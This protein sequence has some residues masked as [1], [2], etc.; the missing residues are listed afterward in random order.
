M[1]PTRLRALLLLGAAAFLLRAGCAVLTQYRPIFP[2][3]YFTDAKLVD[4]VA[5]ALVNKT[6]SETLFFP[7]SLSQRLQV[8]F[9]VRLYSVVGPRPLA[10]KLVNAAAGAAAAVLLAASLLT[11]FGPAAALT[12]GTLFAV[13]PSAVFFTSHNL[14]EAPLA[15]FVFT[16]LA[17]LLPLFRDGAPAARN[18]ARA[19]VALG[20]LTGAGFCRPPVLLAMCTAFAIAFLLE[21][22]RLRK[23]PPRAAAGL[24]CCL[25]APILYA[26]LARAAA[27]INLDPYGRGTNITEV[28]S[29][30]V[31]VIHDGKPDGRTYRPFSP[32]GLTDFRRTRALHDRNWALQN[33]GREIGTQLFP[34]ERFETW[35]DIPAFLP[36][37]AFYA[38]YMPLPGLYPLEGK[39]GRIAAAAENAA[40]LLLSIAAFAMLA[41]GPL[42]PARAALLLLFAAMAAG[43]ALLELDLGSSAR[44]KIIY[45]PLLFPFA[46]EF[47]LRRL[48]VEDLS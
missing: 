8:A 22:A 24:L 23:I 39:P 36:K 5:L 1:S 10:A 6:H 41:R 34:E 20:A 27:R 21:G 3:Y 47:V 33:K 37:G 43:S 17:A 31:P 45:L 11:V 15:F 26:G 38:L 16:A 30:L 13:W 35:L 12:A 29:G 7:G 42:D 40:L 48:G 2:A 25:L 32:Q 46:A 14:K 28:Q 18:A 19:A 44:H 4:D 9:L